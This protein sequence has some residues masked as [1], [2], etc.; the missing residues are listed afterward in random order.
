MNK[1]I[2]PVN[3]LGGTIEIP[4]DKSISHRALIFASMAKG[5]SRIEN[6]STAADCM[7][8]ISCLKALGIKIEKQADGTFIV[9]GKGR[10][11]FSEP[12]NILDAQNSGTTIRLMSGLLAGQFFYS[13]IT[14]DRSLR[15]RPM[16]RIIDP[17]E[18]MGAIIFAR[19]NNSRPPISIIGR[20]LKPISYNM[21]IA[22]AQIKTA[23][24]IAGLLCEG[25]TTINEKY[26]SR[27]HTE[28]M[29]KYLGADIS[30]T[31]PKIE[32]KGGQ[33]ISADIFVPGD[34]SSAIFFIAASLLVNDSN[35]KLNNVGLNPTRTGCLTALKKMGANITIIPDKIRNEEPLGTIKVSS[36]KL[37]A[38]KVDAE[39][40]PSMVDEIPIL[41]LVATQAEGKTIISG[42]EELR[43]KESDRLKAVTDGLRRLGA[44]II[45]KPDGL[46]IDGPTPLTGAEVES[47]GDHRLA[48]TMTIA[49]LIAE[50]QTTI[51]DFEAVNISFPQFFDKLNRLII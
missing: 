48:M 6:L 17:L 11:G 45:E 8:T 14:G 30:G 10:F 49:G 41:A 34:I 44:S 33:L 43:L 36:S 21:P 26:Q 25:T 23:L 1:T 28:R 39:D 47:F 31:F 32:I 46:E 24:M 35:I 42:A 18:S 12:S 51:L 20:K 4:G 50:G 3:K 19:D 5:I 7:S 22:S 13:V 38:I 15:K 9:E 2:T 16:K 37:N 29:F 40:I 27:D